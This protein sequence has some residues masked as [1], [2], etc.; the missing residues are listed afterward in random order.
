MTMEFDVHFNLGLIF[1]KDLKR[2][3]LHKCSSGKLDGFIQKSD[4]ATI[5]IVEFTKEVFQ[6]IDAQ[7]DP[8]DWQILT[9]VSNVEKKWTI[10]AYLAAYD[11]DSL[12][13]NDEFIICD[14][15]NLPEECHP[16]LRWLI[17]MA[18]DFTVFGCTFNQILMK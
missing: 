5:G 16:N 4:P 6:K 2:V 17:P 14:V 3:L 11:L 9:A 15:D 13:L 10:D 18:I 7:I 8:K 1:T 12:K